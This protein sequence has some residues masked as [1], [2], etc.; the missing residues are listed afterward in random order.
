MAFRWYTVVF[1]VILSL[2]VSAISSVAP[3]L[4]G[5]SQLK[6]YAQPLDTDGDGI[7]DK[8]D[9]DIDGDGVDNWDD[10]A[11]EDPLIQYPPANPNPVV[12]N[13]SVTQPEAPALP[14]FDGDQIP[15]NLDND[16]DDDGVPDLEDYEPFNALVQYA[17]QP[18]Q[19][20]PTAASAP[21]AVPGDYSQ[22]TDGD[23]IPSI[24]DPDEDNDGVVDRDDP[25]P[26]GNPTAP[27][28]APTA[29]PPASSGEENPANQQPS[30]SASA[31]AS[32]STGV[33]VVTS[34]PK[35][36]SGST[37]T[38]PTLSIAIIAGVGIVGLRT[39][40]STSEQ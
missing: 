24:I 27:A 28:A 16:D 2:L 23:G 9:T 32:V 35:T 17:P 25:S 37:A 13:P 22:D 5:S 11:P 10:Y 6:A 3:D 15:D 30:K 1:A 29:A 8:T 20:Q 38:W 34:L 26:V 33:P 39:R 18:A 40:T 31:S 7:P 19:P 21:T 4:N 36:G 14:D 12:T